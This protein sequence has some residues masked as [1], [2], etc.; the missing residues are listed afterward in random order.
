[1]RYHNVFHNVIIVCNC[2]IF[3]FEALIL[4][5]V[6][7]YPTFFSKKY[8]AFFGVSLVINNKEDYIL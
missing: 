1:M 6:K 8:S 5:I 7:Y 4:L 3:C 2:N